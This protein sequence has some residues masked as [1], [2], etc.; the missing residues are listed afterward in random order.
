[1][2]RVPTTM[3]L[4]FVSMAVQRPRTNVGQRVFKLV[5]KTWTGTKIVAD[6]LHHANERRSIRNTVSVK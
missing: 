3:G 2:Q 6:T 5:E 1:M 4:A